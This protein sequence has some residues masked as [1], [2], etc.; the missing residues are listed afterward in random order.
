VISREDILQV[1]DPL[2]AQRL[3]WTPGDNVHERAL[4]MYANLHG[5]RAI[6]LAAN[7]LGYTERFFVHNLP[8]TLPRAVIDPIIEAVSPDLVWAVEGC[9]SVDGMA[10]EVARPAWIKISFVTG[11]TRRRL[12]LGG[13]NARMACH[14]V[15]HLN[16]INILQRADDP[17]LPY[18]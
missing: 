12:R 3:T 16:G 9:L 10:V 1:G 5:L 8:G 4:E 13:M 6:G 15:D 14:E 7:Q 11:Y 18:A 2:L 17:Y